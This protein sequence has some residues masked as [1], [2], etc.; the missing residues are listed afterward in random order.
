[1]MTCDDMLST[2]EALERITHEML[3]AASGAEWDRVVELEHSCSAHVTR[4][5]EG[6][7]VALNEAGRQ[8]KIELIKKILDDDRR[9]RDLTTPWMAQLSAMI[10]NTTA[11][12]RLANAYGGV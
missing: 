7:E 10:G 1:M 3:H 6:G 11:Q 8:R 12:R 2:Y 4:L 9:I 5:R